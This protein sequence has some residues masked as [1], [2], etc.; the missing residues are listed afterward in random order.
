M[1]NARASDIARARLVA[2]LVILLDPSL[3]STAAIAPIAA[4]SPITYSPPLPDFLLFPTRFSDLLA[5]LRAHPLIADMMARASLAPCPYRPPYPAR[6]LKPLAR[7]VYSRNLAVYVYEFLVE[8]GNTVNSQVTQT[9]LLEA[10]PRAGQ[11]G[12]VVAGNWPGGG[13]GAWREGAS[14]E[15]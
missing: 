11:L 3:R 12:A 8:F 14:K 15:D 10:A 5:V 1:K 4:P 13:R 2:A 9:T 6:A 7:E